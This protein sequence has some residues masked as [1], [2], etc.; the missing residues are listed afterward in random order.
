MLCGTGKGP[1]PL[2]LY[3]T[4]LSSSGLMDFGAWGLALQ[5]GIGVL[6]RLKWK[7]RERLEQTCWLINGAFLENLRDSSEGSD[8][9]LHLLYF[10]I[11][12]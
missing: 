12:K 6:T 2:M 5:T 8:G 10:L 1:L 3:G 9:V 4:P 11:I 7:T